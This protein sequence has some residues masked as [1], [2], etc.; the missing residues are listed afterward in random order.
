MG[1]GRREDRVSLGQ[2]IGSS[3]GQVAHRTGES[4]RGLFNL[5]PTE[6]REDPPRPVVKSTA[7]NILVPTSV[8]LCILPA[9]IEAL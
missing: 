1:N 8:Y 9:E 7:L 6:G 5:S 2:G 3:R 4:G